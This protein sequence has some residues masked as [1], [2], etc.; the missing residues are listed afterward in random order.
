MELAR[1]TMP[2]NHGDFKRGLDLFN[3]AHF[4]DAHEVL[5]DVWRALPRDRPLRRHVQGMVQLAVAFHHESTGNYVGAR[6]VLER[7]LRN[8]N[9]AD[10]SFPDLDLDWLRAELELWRKYLGDSESAGEKKLD[11]RDVRRHTA[12]ALPKIMLRR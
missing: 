2:L 7:A 9:D 11:T 8:L 1:M 6:S 4:F 10:S 3:R 5:E 12:P